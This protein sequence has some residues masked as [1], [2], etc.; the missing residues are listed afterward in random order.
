VT[1]AKTAAQRLEELVGDH[2]LDFVPIIDLRHPFDADA[3]GALFGLDGFIYLV[4]EDPA[5]G[6]R[7]NAA[8]ILSFKGDLWELGDRWPEHITMWVVC[9]M[10]GSGDGVL[11]MREI[12]SGKVVFEVGT[13]NSDDYYPSY[14]ARWTPPDSPS[15]DA[16]Q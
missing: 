15:T 16:P 4:F 6:Y 13:D 3:T 5:D 11:T 12:A 2:V 14:I 8:P 1:E 9:S 7:S 10:E